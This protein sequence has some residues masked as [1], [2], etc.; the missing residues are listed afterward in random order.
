MSVRS[1]MRN[2]LSLMRHVRTRTGSYLRPSA[3]KF[4]K[5]GK[6]IGMVRDI[7]Q[8]PNG[9]TV[10]RKQLRIDRRGR[11]YWGVILERQPVNLLFKPPNSNIE[12]SIPMD[13]DGPHAEWR[14]YLI[15]ANK[16]ISTRPIKVNTTLYQ[17]S[18]V[19]TVRNPTRRRVTNAILAAVKNE[20]RL[21]DLVLHS[22]EYDP[23]R[24]LYTVGFNS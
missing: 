23:K 24:R 18:P 9:K 10:Q 1:H 20:P 21:S 14:R 3:A 2:S 13:N 6:K 17:A 16:Q 19:I 7:P 22:I 5:A 8:P 4:L 12:L 11:A 15:D